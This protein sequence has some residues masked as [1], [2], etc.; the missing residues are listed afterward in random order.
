M[1]MVR[2]REPATETEEGQ[3][4]R[5]R[6]RRRKKGD[7]S[8]VPP[9]P[10]DRWVRD[11]ATEG[12]HEGLP[13]YTARAEAGSPTGR[14]CTVIFWSDVD[15]D[16]DLDPAENSENGEPFLVDATVRFADGCER[17]VQI[18]TAAS[19][20]EWAS[21]SPRDRSIALWEEERIKAAFLKARVELANDLPRYFGDERYKEMLEDPDPEHDWLRDVVAWRREFAGWGLRN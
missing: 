13:C 17:E 12:F 18:L 9:V 2:W 20:E 14:I 5:G 3:Y 11:R 4:K 16:Y 7:P 6:K 15:E 8:A 21:L 1:A 10:L 19:A